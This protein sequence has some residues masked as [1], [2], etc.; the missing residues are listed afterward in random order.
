MVTEGG[1]RIP[2]GGSPIVVGNHVYLFNTDGQASVVQL[3]GNQFKKVASVNMGERVSATPAVVD[4]ILY[5]RT[6][7]HF[8]AFKTP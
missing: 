4:N 2:S 6:F 8:Y 3:D 5:V 7:G 1:E